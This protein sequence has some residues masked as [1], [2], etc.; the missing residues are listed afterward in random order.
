MKK[1]NV[2]RFVLP[3]LLAALLSSCQGSPFTNEDL[4]EKIFPNGLWD[5]LIQ[6]IAFII[7]ILVVF[8]VGYKPLKKLIKKR[9]DYVQGM[10]DDAKN[11]QVIAKKAADSADQIVEDAKIEAN[12]IIDQSKLVAEQSA[13]TIVEEAKTEAS[14]RLKRAEEEI[15]EAKKASIEETRKQIV[16]VAML[17]SET[18]LEREVNDEDNAKLLKRFV[19]D[20]TNSGEGK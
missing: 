11:N 8:F 10:I 19:D 6:L 2:L 13:K 3:A 18:L 20:V 17:A 14:A 5:F 4:T 16:D 7:L 1:R 15:E 12:K 9:H